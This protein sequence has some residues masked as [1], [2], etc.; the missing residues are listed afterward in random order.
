MGIHIKPV[1][2]VGFALIVCP[3]ST[4]THMGMRV[5][6]TQMNVHALKASCTAKVTAATHVRQKQHV[7]HTTA[8]VSGVG[9]IVRTP[10][11]G[12]PVMLIMIGSS[13][14][15]ALLNSIVIHVDSVVSGIQTIVSVYN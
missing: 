14:Q 15:T 3:L 6:G 7:T 11:T 8:H 13:A 4:V 10:E 9:M 5:N 12:L 2:T 1:I